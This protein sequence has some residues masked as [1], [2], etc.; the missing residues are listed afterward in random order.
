LPDGQVFNVRTPLVAR[1]NVYNALAAIAV[2]HL[3]GIAP[4]VLA[5]TLEHFG[6]VSGRMERIECGQPFT[7]VVDYAH[8]ADSL[9]KVL[10]VLRPVTQGRLIVVFGSAGD[11]DRSKRPQMGAAA[12]RKA[13]FAVITDEDPREED[14]MSIL[15]EIAAGAAAAGGRASADYA[16]IVGRRAGIAAAFALARPGD[17]VLLAGKGHE[18]S[19]VIGRDKLPWDDRTVAREEL[20]A[21]GYRGPAR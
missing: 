17:T 13:D 3:L 14:A 2:G 11:R 16:C 15:R 18:Q 1:F 9:E 12:A 4:A 8:T 5:G 7:V 19:I 21:L 10:D 20:A 6:G